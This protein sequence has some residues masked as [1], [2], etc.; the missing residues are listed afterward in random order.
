MASWLEFWNS[1]NS[2]YAGPAHLS[3]HFERLGRDLRALLPA[4]HG[5]TVLDY[6]CGDALASEHLRAGGNALLLYD[7]SAEVRKRLQMRFAAAAD[8]RIL[9]EGGLERLTPGSVDVVIASSVLQYVG[10]AHLPLLL[11]RWHEVLKPGGRL[12]VADVISP[13]AG[14]LA[15]VED[16][17]RLAW[18]EGFLLSAALGLLRTLLSDYRRLRRDVGLARYRPDDFLER[19]KSAGFLGERLPVNP[20]PNRHRFAFL[21][22]KP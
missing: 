17:L 12:I 19:L 14:L 18:A 6:G 5:L 13:D 2:I 9:D 22:I 16:L 21:G 3:A 11:R 7:A 15:D 10:S 20:G 8:I 1:A 4:D